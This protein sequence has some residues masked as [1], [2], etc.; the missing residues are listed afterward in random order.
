[1]ALPGFFSL[2]TGNSSR[3]FVPPLSEITVLYCLMS[4]CLKNIVFL[5]FFYC[6]SYF[7]HDIKFGSLLCLGHMQKFLDAIFYLSWLCLFSLASRTMKSLR[8][9]PDCRVTS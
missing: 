5:Y 7:G 6:Y 1:M 8:F 2:Q 4:K 3:H 9:H